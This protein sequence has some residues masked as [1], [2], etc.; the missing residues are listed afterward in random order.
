MFGELWRASIEQTREATTVERLGVEVVAEDFSEMQ[1]RLRRGSH[2]AGYRDIT[3]EARPDEEEED[4]RGAEDEVTRE[5]EERGRPRAR[6]EEEDDEIP[7]PSTPLEG[8]HSD[9]EVQLEERRHSIATVVEPEAEL[10]EPNM[11][12]VADEQRTI[13]EAASTVAEE[14]QVS[15]VAANQSRDGVHPNYGAIRAQVKA[16]WERRHD[17]PYFA[18]FFLVSGTEEDEDFQEKIPKSDY[19]VY[20]AHLGTLQ[21]HHVQWRKKSLFNPTAAEGSPIPLRALKKGRR[22]RKVTDAGGVEEQEDEWSL[23]TEKEAKSCWWKGVTEFQVDKHY[24]Q[25]PSGDVS[26]KKKRGEGEVFPHEISETEWPECVKQDKEEFDKVVNSGGLKILSVAESKAVKEKL[27]Q[28]GNLNRTLPSRVVR[29]YKPGDAPGAPR[30]RK[31]RFCLRGDREPDAA[32]LSRFAPTV[33][34]SNLQV[35]IQAAM[36]KGFEGLVGDFKSAFTQSLPLVRERVPI[37]CKSVDG[38]MPGL[39]AEQIAEVK[40][41]VYGL[42]DA[43]MHWRKTLVQFIG[44]ELGYKQLSLDPCTYLLHG[45]DTL[46]G[47]IV[48]EIDDLLMFGDDVHQ[49]KVE[50]LKK[51][52]TFGKLEKLDE[53]GVN[54]NGRR[55][56]R[57]GNTVFID[58]KAFD[59]AA[60][61][62]MFSSLMTH[63]KVQDVLELNKVV[64]KIKQTSELALRIQGFEEGRMRWGVISDA[65]WGNAK[66]GKT[67]GGHLLITF[68]KNMLLGEQAP[69][70]ILH[71]KSGKLQRTVNSTLAAETQSLARGVGDLLWMM[72]MYAEMMNP[73]FRVHEWRKQIRGEGYTAFTKYEKK[74]EIADAV[75]IIDAK[76]LYDL[77]AHETTGGTDRRTALDVQVLREELKELNGRIRWVDHLHMPADA[78]TKK[79]GHSEM[80]VKILKTGSYGITEE[81]ATLHSR[82]EERQKAGYNRR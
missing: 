17:M 50:T 71:W 77:L 56:K 27:R 57:E 39:E 24:L 72:V 15:S 66:G 65:S 23:F 10:I 68:D 37:Y 45:G 73:Q 5:G 30:S 43:P 34:T 18:E 4:T 1:E 82:F 32:F 35:L 33:T 21:R 38:S 44:E 81:A 6:F 42:C 26:Q 76:S 51:R 58:M 78:L 2:K 19:W 40:L 63:M 13:D 62:S 67:Q 11:Q 64:A 16:R 53:K 14:D 3:S 49:A 25:C 54:F 46:H 61:A 29:R 47:M 22:T 31:S 12:D 7:S 80:L 79:Q 55:L 20:D 48:V 41:G 74:E 9:E 70:N 59:A 8:P 69:C 60:A 28:E 36:N 52:F 75:A